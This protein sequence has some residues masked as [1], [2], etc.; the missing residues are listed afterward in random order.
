VPRTV[1]GIFPNQDL[2]RPVR[3]RIAAPADVFA[4]ISLVNAAFAIETF[5]DGPRIDKTRIEEMMG[6]GEFL[7]GAED[8]TGRIVALVYTAA[9]AGI[10]ACS[11]SSLRGRAGAWDAG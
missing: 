8:G 11:P 7:A 6:K 3:I 9:N 10:L 1:M 4:A 5:I 2:R